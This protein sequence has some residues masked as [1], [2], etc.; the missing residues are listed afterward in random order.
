[1]RALAAP[2][3]A[4]AAGLKAGRNSAVWDRAAGEDGLRGG[5]AF[6]CLLMMLCF[7]DELLG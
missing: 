7:G 3:A 1:M 4:A 6:D 2:A 5:A